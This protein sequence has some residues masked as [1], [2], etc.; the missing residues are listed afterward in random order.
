MSFDPKKKI[1]ELKGT[2]Y[3][4]RVCWKFSIKKMG[5]P[6]NIYYKYNTYNPGYHVF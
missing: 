3:L 6:Y 2:P 5:R 1:D 4:N